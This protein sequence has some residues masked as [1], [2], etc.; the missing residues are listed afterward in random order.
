MAIM[1]FLIIVSLLLA[2]G[3]L[4]A[5]LFAAKTGQFDDEYTPA[6]RILFD[7]KVITDTTPVGKATDLPPL[8]TSDNEK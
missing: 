6:I 2:V 5:Y 7:D 4:F 3:F 8:S 1:L